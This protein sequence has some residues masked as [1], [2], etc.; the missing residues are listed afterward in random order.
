MEPGLPERRVRRDAGRSPDAPRRGRHDRGRELPSPRG[1]RAVGEAGEE[2]GGQAE[3]EVVGEGIWG[4]L[5]AP[6]SLH[7]IS[8]P[9]SVTEI[10][11]ILT[12]A[13]T[14]RGALCRLEISR[15]STST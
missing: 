3:R 7:R 4:R 8:S 2:D 9:E 6:R 15:R 14:G 13:N 1:N 11:R 10:P 12:P 5:R